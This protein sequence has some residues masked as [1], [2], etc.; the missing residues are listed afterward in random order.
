MEWV[1]PMVIRIKKDGRIRIFV[2]YK[3]LNVAFVIYPFPTPFNKEILN[4]VAGCKIYSF[5]D[6][7]LGYHQVRITKEDQEKTT[8]TTEYRSF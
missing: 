8:F 6:G 7:F 5:T 4:G 3:Y 2:E 1:S